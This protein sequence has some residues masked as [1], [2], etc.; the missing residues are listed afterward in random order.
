MKRKRGIDMNK[1]EFL[2][3]LEATLRE[4]NL[5]K[6]VINSNLTYYDRY[7]SDRIKFGDTEEDSKLPDTGCPRSI[8]PA[9]A[10][11]ITAMGN[12]IFDKIF[13]CNLQI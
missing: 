4:N 5:S 12:N 3:E 8:G 6:D 1:K 10:M 9:A 2:N 11:L 13:I 7:I